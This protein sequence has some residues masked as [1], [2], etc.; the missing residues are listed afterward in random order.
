MRQVVAL[1]ILINGHL[2]S[3]ST[4]FAMFPRHIARGEAVDELKLVGC[5]CDKTVVGS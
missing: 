1:S 2:L 3:K 4:F 5:L